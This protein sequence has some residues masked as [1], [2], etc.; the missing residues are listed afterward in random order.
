MVFFPDN[1]FHISIQMLLQKISVKLLFQKPC[2]ELVHIVQHIL[3]CLIKSSG[4]D[5]RCP[6]HIHVHPWIIPERKQRCIHILDIDLCL[7]QILRGKPFKRIN[8]DCRI[9]R[10]HDVRHQCII[11]FNFLQPSFSDQPVQNPC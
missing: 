5:K 8:K 3:Q 6:E 11:I 10:N 7:L 9:I 4:I 2:K 1:L